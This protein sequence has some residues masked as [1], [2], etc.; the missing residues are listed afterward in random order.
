[1]AFFGLW[2]PTQPPEK[3]RL[4]FTKSDQTGSNANSFT[5]D[6]VAVKNIRFVGNELSVT[7]L[8]DLIFPGTIVAFAVHQNRTNAKVVVSAGQAVFT[9]ETGTVVDETLDAWIPVI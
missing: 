1:M 2:S 4:T 3:L 9:R 8:S 5:S 7:W 6:T